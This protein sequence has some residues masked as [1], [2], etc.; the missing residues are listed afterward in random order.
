MAPDHRPRS[1]SALFRVF[2]AAAGHDGLFCPSVTSRLFCQDGVVV[3]SAAGRTVMTGRL[4]AECVLPSLGSC[5]G[6][7]VLYI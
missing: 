5:V 6:C 4:L 1:G 2:A 3:G 7:T